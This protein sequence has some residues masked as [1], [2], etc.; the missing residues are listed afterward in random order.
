MQT[1]AHGDKPWALQIPPAI[2][3]VFGIALQ[4]FPT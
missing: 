3:S 2:L 4:A 1:R